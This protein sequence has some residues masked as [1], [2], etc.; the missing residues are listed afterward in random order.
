MSA[1]TAIAVPAAPAG[2][3]FLGCGP[4]V[5]EQ[6]AGRSLKDLCGDPDHAA[7]LDLVRVLEFENRELRAKAEKR[8]TTECTGCST[9]TEE[10]T[11]LRELLAQHEKT[12]AELRERANRSSANSSMPPSS[13]PPDAKRYP[14]KRPSSKRK[15]GGQPGHPGATFKLYTCDNADI[16]VHD[17]QPEE[18]AH[19]GHNEFGEE[20]GTAYPHQ[21][22]DPPDLRPK[23]DEHRLHSRRCVKCGG[24]TRAPHPKGVPTSNFGPRTQAMISLMTGYYALSLREAASLMGCLLGIAISVGAISDMQKRATAALA[25]PVAE[26]KESV[27]Q[28]T[29]VNNDATGWKQNGKRR[30]AF[31]SVTPDV[32]SFDI[33][34]KHNAEVV[35][36][37]FGPDFGGIAA[38]DRHTIYLGIPNEQRQICNSHTDRDFRKMAERGGESKDIGEQGAELERQMFHQWHRFQRGEI[39]RPQLQ[40]ECTTIGAALRDVLTKGTTCCKHPDSGDKKHTCIH[41]KTERTCKNLLDVLPS[42]FTFATHEN[43]GPTNNP[44][45]QQARFL[46]I[47]RKLSFGSKSDVGS[48]FIEYMM[49]VGATLQKQGRSVLPYLV[50]VIVA[51]LHGEAPPSLLPEAPGQPSSTSP[52]Q[53][54][55]INGSEAGGAKVAL[56]T[57]PPPKPPLIRKAV[58]KKTE[59]AAA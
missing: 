9:L 38:T 55:A 45:E 52:A 31:V 20:V 16:T 47:K 39:T 42:L 36:K 26:V 35:R 46:V 15:R 24:V 37:I 2:M 50:A 54:C 10:N 21:V 33:T 3:P 34:E 23:V 28:A 7:L 19:C 32:V 59:P 12:I 56:S 4:E 48:R 18:C 17:H 1:R 27:K 57:R 58:A 51:A 11:D 53:P 25:Q 14:K 29:R 30:Y 5:F 13:D 8:H 43:V 41:K 44:A 22:V 49:T 6:P 40:E